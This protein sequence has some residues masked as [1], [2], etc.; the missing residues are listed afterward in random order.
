MDTPTRHKILIVD[1]ETSICE[2]VSRWMQREG[3]EF[4]AVHS[5]EE[6]L[7]VLAVESFS[8]M[9]SDINMPGK[10]GMELLAIVQQTYPDLSVIMA[11]AL[12]DRKIAT[13]A[14]EMGAYGYVIKPFER[15]EVLINVANGLRLRRLEMEN[16]AHREHLEMLVAERTREL[17][18]AEQEVR[19]SREETIQRLAK[20][21]EFRDDETAQHTFRMSEYCKMMAVKLGFPEERCELIRMASPLHDVGKIGT[22]DHIL[23]K[24]G[25]LT[26]EEFEIIKQHTLIGYRILSS[27]QSE[28]LEVASVIAWTHHE[29][30]DGNGYPRG[31][32]GQDIPLE[33]RIAAI[34]D[35][36]DAL[37]SDRVYKKAFSIEQAVEI[38]REGKGS[39]FDPELLDLFL[40]SMDDV[41][42]IR[43]DFSD[44]D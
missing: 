7:E 31:L 8:L 20:A 44:T 26:A 3:Y 34:C 6:A 9:L 5:A 42:Q 24:P 4:R 25:K 29:K 17:E 14:L 18:E 28:L 40:D 11:T 19:M 39:H 33:G 35:V 38:L 13:Q 12:D 37:T 23:L 2:I 41:L 16:R 10:S 43:K 1:D 21:A 15:N 27:S 30:Y 32:V 36:F 22:P